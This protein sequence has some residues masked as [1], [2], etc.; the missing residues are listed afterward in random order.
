MTDE[1]KVSAIKRINERRAQMRR[2]FGEDSSLYRQYDNAINLA[3]PDDAL[4]PS[5][6]ISH[7]KKALDLINDQDL[8]SLLRKETAGD[9]KK[10]AREEAKRESEETGEAVNWRDIIEAQE[11]VYEV[12]EDDYSE[13]Y[14][15]VKLYWN[16]VG[17]GHPKPA[18]T[19][20]KQIIDAQS[21]IRYDQD[22]GDVKLAQETNRN[23]RD[24]LRKRIEAEDPQRRY[25][26]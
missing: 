3:I 24:K 16:E 14:E 17:K 21:D 10:R 25:F 6:N 23:I 2:D 26:E 7:G 1:Q 12:M 15:A 13:F 18:Y 11:V 9:I 5:G 22:N 4:L 19:T 20:I 8:E